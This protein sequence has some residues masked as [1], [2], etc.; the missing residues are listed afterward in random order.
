MLWDGMDGYQ[1]RY[2]D[3]E[4]KGAARGL[5]PKYLKKPLLV[6]GYID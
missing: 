1:V 3:I 4:V 6:G 5:D 2:M